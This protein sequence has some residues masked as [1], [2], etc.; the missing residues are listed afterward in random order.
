[1]CTLA[2]LYTCSKTLQVLTL[3]W[4]LLRQGPEGVPVVQKAI[5][6]AP[7]TLVDNW[8][9]EV[10]IIQLLKQAVACTC[11]K[12]FGMH[13][14]LW[15]HIQCVTLCPSAHALMVSMVTW[16]QRAALSVPMY[17]ALQC[18]CAS[19][20]ALPLHLLPIL[21]LC[22]L[23]QVKKWLGQ[24]RVRFI[25]L[26]NVRAVCMWMQPIICTPMV[27]AGPDKHRSIANSLCSVSS[28]CLMPAV[29]KCS[30]DD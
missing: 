9:K 19:L 3:L 30:S 8:A 27:C 28:L 29:H 22:V 15:L 23:I 21:V 24:E 12:C 25:K 5:V 26:T 6:V 18:L 2:L 10:C 11:M 13:R 7:A 4:T 16:Y 20:Q 1:M 14:L 17:T